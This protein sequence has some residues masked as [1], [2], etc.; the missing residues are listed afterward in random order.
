MNAFDQS[1]SRL[2][3]EGSYVK[4]CIL[5]IIILRCLVGIRVEMLDSVIHISFGGWELANLH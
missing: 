4:S 1:R 5:A 3:V 2:C